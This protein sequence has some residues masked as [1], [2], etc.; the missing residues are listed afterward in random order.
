MFFLERE[1]F[2]FQESKIISPLFGKSFFQASAKM[3]GFL[4]PSIRNFFFEL[5]KNIPRLVGLNVLHVRKYKK[6]FCF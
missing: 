6:L 2:V 3:V 4:G 1:K 5:K